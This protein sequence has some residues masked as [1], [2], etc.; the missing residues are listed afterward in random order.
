M[1]AILANYG[2]ELFFGL[3]SAG[4]L[5]FCKYLWKQNKE[6]A[7]LQKQ[8]ENRQYRQMIIDEI[9]PIIAELNQAEEEI[10]KIK[11]Q[12]AKTISGLEDSEKANHEEMYADLKKIQ[13]ENER[14][15]ALILNSYKFRLIQLCKFHLRDGY[16]SQEDYD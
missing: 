8:E 12:G 6:L 3:V 15:F 10:K 11:K 4:L 7:R 5:W 13:E 9:E 2:L 14:R 1:S 16:I